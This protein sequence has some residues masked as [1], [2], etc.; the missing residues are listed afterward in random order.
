M[1]EIDKDGEIRGEHDGKG[2]PRHAHHRHH[3]PNVQLL[4]LS[5]NGL[6]AVL[7]DVYLRCG[8]LLSGS[9][10]SFMLRQ[11]ASFN[12][13]VDKRFCTTTLNLVV[14][15]TEFLVEIAKRRNLIY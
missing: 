8:K 7:P 6:H 3:P 4:V 11:Q 5:A 15:S 2:Q 9:D 1:P 10:H 12:T 13:I 14:Y